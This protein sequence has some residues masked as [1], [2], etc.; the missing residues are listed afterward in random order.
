MS[1]AERVDMRMDPEATLDAA[2]F[3]NERSEEEIGAALRDFGEERR[4]RQFAGRVVQYRD[5][6]VGG[7]VQTGGPDPTPLTKGTRI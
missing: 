2:S 3:V 5:E 6:Q 4:W 7:W 1:P